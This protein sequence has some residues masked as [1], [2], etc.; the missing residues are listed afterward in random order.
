MRNKLLPVFLFVFLFVFAKSAHAATLTGSNTTL[1]DPRPSQV[2][3][4]YT[5]DFGSV[6]T[7]AT[8]CFKLSFATTATGTTVIPTGMSSIGASYDVV[9]SDYVPDAQ[10]WTIGA[11]VNGTVTLTNATGETPASASGRT[12]VLAGITNGS[13]AD[14]QYYIRF[15]TFNNVD[16]VSSPV[17][18][19][20]GVFIFTNGQVVSL[21]ID[22]SLVFTINSVGSGVTVVTGATTTVVTTSTTIPFG[23]VNSSVNAIAGHDLTV[24]TNAGSGYTVYTRYTGVLATGVGGTIPNHTGTNG[25]PTS[26][27]AAGTAA[28]GYTTN[29]YS[30]GTGTAGRFNSNLW[31][32]FTTTNDEVAF[33]SAGVSSETT[34]VGYQ[35]GVAANTP[36]GSYSTTVIM[37]VVPSY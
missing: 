19:G 2:G 7:S 31:A 9:A 30:L 14:T 28:F 5:V 35:V 1:S 20:I 3:V 6:T 23:T 4:T 24:G 13:V 26:F 18:S 29:D 37:T 15:A 11:S 16:C 25:T 17:D 10:T 27:S 21:T 32:G 34:R 8:K 36:A 12:L 33:S 22:P